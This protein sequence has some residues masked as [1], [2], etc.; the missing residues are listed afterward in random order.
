MGKLA[1][2]ESRLAK[3]DSKLKLQKTNLEVFRN[4]FILNKIKT[5]EISS[6]SANGLETFKGNNNNECI[7][8]I[9]LIV[10]DVFFVLLMNS[11]DN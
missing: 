4:F 11:G 3:Y 1:R 9:C 8:L 5:W 6:F 10:T 7:T 2:N